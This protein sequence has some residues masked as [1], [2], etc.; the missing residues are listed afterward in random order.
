[1]IVEFTLSI[2]VEDDYE[3]THSEIEANET[4]FAKILSAMEEVIAKEDCDL[5]DSSWDYV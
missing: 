2:N 4:L 1:M 5:N 3:A